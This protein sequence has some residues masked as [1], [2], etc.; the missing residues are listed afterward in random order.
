[1]VLVLLARTEDPRLPGVAMAAASVPST[2]A[3][4]RPGTRPLYTPARESIPPAAARRAVP[5]LPAP[6]ARPARPA[7]PAGEGG[8]ARLAPGRDPV[9]AAP[10]RSA[11]GW[12]RRPRAASALGA[13]VMTQRAGGQLR[14]RQAGRGRGTVKLS[15]AR[16]GSGCGRGADSAGPAAPRAQ[17][18]FG[19]RL[20][21]G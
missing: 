1:M 13:G 12:T 16:R 4:R 20:P 2:A 17:A 8:C 5:A 6:P 11:R 15:R 9:P 14:R 10:P 7:R 18:S 3:L 21:A 19:W